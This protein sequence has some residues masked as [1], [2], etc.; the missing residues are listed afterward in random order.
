MYYSRGV[1]QNSTN[2]YQGG[3]G[4]KKPDFYPYVLF[5]CSLTKKKIYISDI[6][7][8]IK[9]KNMAGQGPTRPNWLEFAF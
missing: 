9:I 8:K 2:S 4:V 1:G 3:G 6:S 5:G 7:L